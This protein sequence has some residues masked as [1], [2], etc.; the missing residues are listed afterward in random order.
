MFTLWVSVCTCCRRNVC[1]CVWACHCVSVCT[2]RSDL[3]I[4]SAACLVRT[5]IWSCQSFSAELQH[6]NDLA[7]KVTFMQRSILF[8][9]EK[10][11]IQGSY[12]AFFRK[13]VVR[14]YVLVSELSLSSET[15]KGSK[16]H[17]LRGLTDTSQ[18]PSSPI[19]RTKC[20]TWPLS[21]DQSKCVF[22]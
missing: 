20:A 12:E 8:I 17:I 3:L 2:H 10:C 1:I 5:L 19:K 4:L 9:W 16:L 15:N 18:N 21:S 6:L 11:D 7:T 14:L 22:S 13:R